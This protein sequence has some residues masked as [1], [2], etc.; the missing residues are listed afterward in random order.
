[1][2]VERVKRGAERQDKQRNV[3]QHRDDELVPEL[4]LVIVPN[5][6]PMKLEL[7]YQKREFR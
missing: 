3:K 4:T 2:A 1:M 5:M 7:I 6:E